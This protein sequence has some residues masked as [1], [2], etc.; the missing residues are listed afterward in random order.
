MQD[1]IEIKNFNVDSVGVESVEMIRTSDLLK[2]YKDFGEDGDGI[3]FIFNDP[4]T[5]CVRHFHAEY[6]N[7]GIRNGAWDEYMSNLG[8]VR[9]SHW[10]VG[11]SKLSR[12]INERKEEELSALVEEIIK[13]E[14]C[15]TDT[16]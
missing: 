7:S 1:F 5:G 14:Q 10:D 8:A 3:V 6:P 2:M 13:E 12:E 11:L 16:K 9:A 15:L 4:D